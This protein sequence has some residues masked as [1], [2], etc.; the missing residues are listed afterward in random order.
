MVFLLSVASFLS[1]LLPYKKVRK[2]QKRC[3]L[4]VT[5]FDY[6]TQKQ[7]LAHVNIIMKYAPSI[8]GTMFRV[9]APLYRQLRNR[10]QMFFDCNL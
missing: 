2:S 7:L 8:T 6:V 3:R 9:H 4:T 5:A 10:F 1:L